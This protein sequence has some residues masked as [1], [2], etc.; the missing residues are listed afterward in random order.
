MLPIK[1]LT[2]DELRNLTISSLDEAIEVLGYTKDEHGLYFYDAG[3]DEPWEAC[4]A[5]S[6]EAIQNCELFTS[7]A[8]AAFYGSE[9]IAARIVEEM[10][11][12]IEAH[13]LILTDILSREGYVPLSQQP[14][15]EW[16]QQ[17]REHQVESLDYALFTLGAY[18]DGHHLVFADPEETP[19][20]LTRYECAMKRQELKNTMPET[21]EGI[22]FHPY[23]NARL[24]IS[25]Y[26][27][28]IAEL[29]SLV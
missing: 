17:I 6:R 9:E 22:Y 12:Y 11:I 1:E 21:D 14:E 16:K 10:R 5:T 25:A 2:T 19:N 23:H 3:H 8:T 26:D 13:S 18:L 7:Q 28:V 29:K 20:I 27:F 4:E 15:L 24:A